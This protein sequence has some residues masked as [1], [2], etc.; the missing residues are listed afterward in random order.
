MKGISTELT[1]DTTHSLAGSTVGTREISIP[2]GPDDLLALRLPATG[3]F[4]CA[5]L[6][7]FWPDLSNP[8]TDY[9]S[10]LERALDAPE[11]SARLEHHV[12]AG[13]SVAIVVDDPSRW[14]PVREALPIVLRRLHAAGVARQDVTICIGAGRHAAV[15]GNAMRRRL[16]ES[17]VA[18]YRCLA[19]PVDDL[20]AYTDLGRTT[21]G[22][23]VRIFR[24]VAEAG[25][26]I[27]IGSVL[28]HLQ[29][30]FGGG[31]KLILPGTSHRSTLGSIHRQGLDGRSRLADMLGCDA[32]SNPM[33]QA[34]HAAAERVGPCWSISHLLG[35]TG[36]VL[37][38]VAGHPLRVQDLLA[39]EARRRLE[40]PTIDQADLVI[41]G[42]HPWPGD[43]MQSFKV[44][45]HHRAA[46][47][48]GGAL[49]G[50]FWT[51]PDEVARSC[52]LAT[53]RRVAATG[54]FGA[55]AIQK[56]LPIGQR[57]VAA[58][59]LP[60]AFMLHWA[61]EL[62]VDRTVLI[63]APPLRE[64]VGSRLGPVH[65]FADQASMWQAAAAALE[66]HGR[67]A[68]ARPLRVR[69]FPYGGLTYIPS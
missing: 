6:D 19:P 64:R 16:G 39:T 37:R 32:A 55:W 40:A 56:F 3:A 30:G 28:P 44:L 21:H 63:Y 50:L 45:L 15:D 52:P 11:D 43:P 62:V 38:I 25:L 57:M 69:I 29:A 7:A 4:A 34:I 23:P 13:I 66:H 22:I 41:A 10:A 31:Y 18:D 8:L 27:L 42:N 35:G 61:R 48:T 51:D 53:I 68:H 1:L 58:L 65:L 5:E 26:R 46:C 60:A 9:T 17:I 20:T 59:G 36:Q 54:R 67:A 14:T 49:A 47:R 33:R 24:P 12:A 2:W